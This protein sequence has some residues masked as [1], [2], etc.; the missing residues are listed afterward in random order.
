MET[1]D[2]K[3]RGKQFQRGIGYDSPVFR[4]N[5]FEN[6]CRPKKRRICFVPQQDSFD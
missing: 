2:F 3:F 4:F 5:L 1:L 6:F